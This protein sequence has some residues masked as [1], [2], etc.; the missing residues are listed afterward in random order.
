MAQG[1]TSAAS[2]EHQGAR[3][4]NAGRNPTRPAFLIKSGRGLSAVSV[5]SWP[6]CRR[7]P[8]PITPTEGIQLENRLVQCVRT[9]FA[10]RQ[11]IEEQGRTT[12][13]RRGPLD[14]SQATLEAT[15]GRGSARA[16]PD[17]TRPESHTRSQTLRRHRLR[18]ANLLQMRAVGFRDKV[19]SARFS[20][21][22][23]TCGRLH[24][25]RQ[26]TGSWPLSLG[27]ASI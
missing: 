18:S 7:T 12:F 27:P 9:H 17:D 16:V 26:S 2:D 14:W 5:R 6:G 15:G 24:V 21:G 13:S 4:R 11:S 1:K 20:G 23:L 19:A 8:P 25:T 22:R 10:Q 3:N